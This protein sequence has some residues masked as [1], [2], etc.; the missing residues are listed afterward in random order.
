MLM[1]DIEALKVEFEKQTTHIVEDTRMEL[2]DQN[3]CGDLYK[4]RCV[5]EKSKRPINYYWEIFNIHQLKIQGKMVKLRKI[6]R[7]NLFWM[8]NML[9][10]KM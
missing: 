3:I 9:R 2:N 5:L 7:I 4:S 8:M 1:A 10:R 6:P